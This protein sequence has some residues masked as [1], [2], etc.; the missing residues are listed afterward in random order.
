M[1]ARSR[2]RFKEI[3]NQELKKK[4]EEQKTIKIYEAI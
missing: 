1:A 3:R 2:P 4:D